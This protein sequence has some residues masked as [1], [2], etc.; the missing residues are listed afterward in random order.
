M[1]DFEN[2]ELEEVRVG[3]LEEENCSLNES[4]NHLSVP[5][6]GDTSS[7]LSQKSTPLRTNPESAMVFCCVLQTCARRR[8]V[9]A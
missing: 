9:A 5:E 7:G 2:L 8:K 1:G 4:S 6:P 3:G